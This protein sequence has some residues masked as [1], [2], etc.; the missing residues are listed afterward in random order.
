MSSDVYKLDDDIQKDAFMNCVE[1]VE[2]DT[3]TDTNI[4]DYFY[5]PFEHVDNYAVTS[6]RKVD[7]I[8]SK[9]EI[10]GVNQSRLSSQ[11]HGQIGIGNNSSFLLPDIITS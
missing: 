8:C 4:Q 9:I 3:F 7:T 5:N 6:W 1:N 2:I 11:L 10:D